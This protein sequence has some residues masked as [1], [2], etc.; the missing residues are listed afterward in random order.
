MLDSVR[1]ELRGTLDE[2]RAA[3]LHK[4]ERVIGTPQSATVAVT[5]GGNPGE[6]LNFCAN[7][8]LGLADHPEV[9]AAAHEALD[10]WGYGL[11]SVRFICG[12]QEVHKELEQRI[13][14]FLGQEDT[15][16]YS[17]CFD[18]NGGVFETLLGPDD[19]V[20]SDA[21]NHASIIDGIRLCK[22][23]RFRYANRDL[24]DLER[25]LKEA[26]SAGRKLVVT[27]GVFSMDGYVAPL[28]EICDLA[29]QYGAMVMVDDSHAVGFVGPGG[30]GTP[31][32]HGVMDRVD[33]I[34]GTLGKAL[35]G[36]SG[37]YVAARA[38]IVALLRQR[39]RPYLFS[40]SLAPVIAAAS[41]KVLDLLESAGDLRERLHANTALF[42]SRMTEEGFDILPGDHA[43]APVMI[44]D[45]AEA[46]RMAELLLERGV[47]VI[48]FSYPVVPQG[49]A[50]IRVQ[51]SA[52]HSTEDVNRAVDAFIG[53][54]AALGG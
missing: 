52:A 14:G 8:Y 10:R 36:A 43:I 37:G 49:Q 31:E 13:S 17:S 39:S 27:D 48:G 42:R 44:G 54:R 51:L 5:A 41:L 20:I 46:A 25:Q 21:L 26:G 47:Y 32:L 6:V 35:G 9:I 22:A 33:I 28:R 19:A 15:I 24:A 38:E 40:N 16:L 53:A 3:G 12:T 7:N 23:R 18:A 1:N 4:P 2:I 34:T 11:A 29:D 45:A 50:R 30:R